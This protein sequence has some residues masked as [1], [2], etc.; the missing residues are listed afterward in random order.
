MTPLVSVLLPVRNGQ[1]YLNDALQSLRHQTYPNI[2]ILVVDD[3]SDDYT[4][5]MLQ[6]WERQLWA[7]S[8][9]TQN[10]GGSWCSGCCL[11]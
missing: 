3:G 10:R 2:E 7:C 1:K 11:S 9:L 5:P 6:F 8:L 4:L